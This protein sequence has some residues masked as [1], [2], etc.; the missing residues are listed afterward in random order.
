MDRYYSKFC[1]GERS[2]IRNLEK[3]KG[4]CCLVKYIIEN[5]RSFIF[6]DVIELLRKIC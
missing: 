6:Y 5:L 2:Y 4:L 3:K 1:N